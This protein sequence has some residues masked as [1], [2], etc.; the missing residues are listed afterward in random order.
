MRSIRSQRHGKGM[1]VCAL[2]IELLVP[3]D[4]WDTGKSMRKRLVASTSS[5]AGNKS[6]WSCN[7]ECLSWV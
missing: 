3:D 1:N 2:A 7:T 4:V 5:G 6:T